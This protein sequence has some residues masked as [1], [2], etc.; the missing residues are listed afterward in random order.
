MY[1][2]SPQNNRRSVHKTPLKQAHSHNDYTRERPLVDALELGFTSVEA[3][4]HLLDGEL[5]VGHTREEAREGKTLEEL[6]LEPLKER[7]SENEGRVFEDGTPLTLLVDVKTEGSD[8]YRELRRTLQHYSNI[9]AE[10]EEGESDGDPVQ[11]ILSG[12]VAWA[13]IE[14]QTHRYVAVDGRLGDLEQESDPTLVPM[15]SQ[16]WQDHFLWHGYFPMPGS[17]REKLRGLVDRAHARGKKI[18]FWGTPDRTDVWREERKA[19]VDVIN[20]DNLPKLE[21]FL[22]GDYEPSL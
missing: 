9:V 20:A 11:V 2:N 12:N 13:E 10:Y 4:I 21:E 18:R 14:A 16:S 19:G 6:Y 5:R 15:I 3:D 22:R 8:T 7:V 17:E 1:I